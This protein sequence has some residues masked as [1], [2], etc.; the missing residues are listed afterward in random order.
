[1]FV[2]GKVTSDLITLDGRGQAVWKTFALV[3]GEHQI[4]ASYTAPQGSPLMPSTSLPQ[5]HLVR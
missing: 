3:P 4:T 5:T 1:M 2:D